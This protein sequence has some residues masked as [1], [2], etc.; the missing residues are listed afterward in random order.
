[1]NSK[2]I[3]EQAKRNV[4][5]H[6]HICLVN[7]LYNPLGIIRSLA[8]EGISPIVLVYGK[9]IHLVSNSKYVGELH[10]FETA[11]SAFEFMVSHYM[12]EKYKPFV[13]NDSDRVTLLLDSKYEELKE[14]FYFC[15]S[16]GNISPLMQKLEQTRL[17]EESGLIIPREE[18]LKVGSL[19]QTLR[20][21]VITKAATSA[22]GKAW[23]DQTFICHDEKELQEAY[24]NIH[25]EDILV[26]EYVQKK[27]ELCIE[28]ICINS[29]EQV[30]MPYVCEYFRFTD[31]SFGS[32]IYITPSDKHKGLLEKI[33]MLL[34]RMNYSGIFEI[35][36]IEGKDGNLYFME[37]NLRNSG[38][39]YPY[40]YGGFNLPVRWAI[41]T[42]CGQIYNDD[43]VPKPYFTAMQDVSDLLECLK[44]KRITFLQWLKDFH[45][46]D[47]CLVYDK[48]DWKP[49]LAEIS[50]SGKRKLNKFFR[51]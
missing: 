21:P 16:K 38:W 40:T 28:G 32:Y 13:Y 19:P 31:S 33:Q 45:R 42:L 41:S 12:N 20:Y 35:E 9:D 8:R 18:L 25:V 7:D 43:F 29:G 15:N 22:T 3:F 46:V 50:A 4:L 6:K 2:N 26:Q 37:V 51:K 47:C 14:H 39:S 24:K 1:M 36:F 44:Y 10:K 30:A 5:L 11:E 23:K 17:A 49:F 27:N 34:Q 48:K